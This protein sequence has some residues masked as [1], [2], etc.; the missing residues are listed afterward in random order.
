MLY[1]I[2]KGLQRIDIFGQTITLNMNKNAYYTTSFGG[3]SSIMIICLLSLIFYSN[4]A[5]FFTKANV[6]YNSQTAFSNDPN[7][8]KMSDEN[9]MFALSIDQNNYTNFPFFNITMEQRSLDGTIKKSTTQIPLEPCTLNRFNN[10]VEYQGFDTNF[11]DS[12]N[13]LG[14]DQWLCPKVNYSLELQ[15]TYSSETFKFIKIIVS[16]CQNNSNSTYWNPICANE[17]AKSQYLQANG[18]FKLQVFQINTMVNPQKAKDHKTMYLDSDMYFSFV[19]NQLSRLA[20]VYYRSYVINNDLSLLP[21]EDIQKE[22]IIV[23]KAEDFRDLTELG[24]NTDSIYA[25][26]YLRRS[27][28]TEII[29]R[30]YEKLGDLLSYLGGFMQIFKVIFGF[31]IAFYNRTSM[32]IELSNRLYDFKEVTNRSYVRKGAFDQNLGVITTP[33]D[34][35]N[36]ILNN[37]PNPDLQKVEWKQF[38]HKLVERSQPIKLNLKILINELSCGYFFNNTNSSFFTK[39]MMKINNELDLHNILH[40]LQEISKLKSVLLQ[41]P[42]QILFNFTPKPIITLSQENNVPSRIEL[43]YQNRQSYIRNKEETPNEELFT[44]LQEAYRTVIDEMENN[45]SSLICQKTINFKLTKQIDD[46]LGKFLRSRHMSCIH[47]EEKA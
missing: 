34:E 17:T 7:Y 4:I 5:D 1:S 21:Y 45:E 40:Q 37:Q 29:D 42:Q 22:E 33:P 31:F 23:R 46:E 24:R 30:N 8:M 10:V 43:D 20:N 11:N 12:F 16:D 38:I 27:P 39:A 3:C 2:Q 44:S 9:A 14:M 32:L 35:M 36:I 18:Q 15:G 19:P 25:T 13:Y 28:F 47:Q 41:K 6:Y 26:I